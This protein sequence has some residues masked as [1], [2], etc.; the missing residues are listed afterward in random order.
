VRTLLRPLLI[1]LVATRMAIAGEVS[2]ELSRKPW[3][4]TFWPLKQCWLAFNRFS[5]GLSPFEKYDNYVQITRGLN[6]GAAAREA[7][8]S[9]GHNEAPDAKAEQWT[10]HC[11]GW[12]PAALIE[13]EP[14]VDT[15]IKLGTPVTFFRL[16][17]NYARDAKPGFAQDLKAAYS[18]CS[19]TENA[20][21][22]RT[23]DLKGMLT[24]IYTQCRSHFWGTRYNGRAADH[25][26]SA[27]MDIKPHVMHQLLVSCIKEK[28]QGLVFDVDPGYM[29]WNQPVYKFES[30]WTE[31]GPKLLVTTTVW[32]ANDNGVDPD[33]HGLESQ[34]R[35]YTYTMSRDAAGNVVDSE[36]TGAS[37]DNHPDFIWQPYGVLNQATAA[38]LDL[39]VVHEMVANN[40]KT[41]PV[42]PATSLPAVPPAGPS[43]P[44][45]ETAAAP[46]ANPTATA[47]APTSNSTPT[48]AAPTENSTLTAAAPTA[49]STSTAAA[50]T[51]NSTATAA[52]P[53]ANSTP[54]AVAD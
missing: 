4:G 32:W 51:E 10:G 15:T 7:D 20:L 53:T 30:K 34:N 52:A 33:F 9:N 8:P 35:T 25:N 46:T 44:T 37:V 27:Y 45:T 50:P 17:L 1:L 22:L 39:N 41:I 11:H 2:G 28:D 24:E 3:S 12:C 43:V 38:G 48:A 19:A 18:P 47:A 40:T 6:P 49:N 31:D 5:Q 23:A 54:T 42:W 13:P 36:W 29:V 14:P 16:S 26:S 21:E